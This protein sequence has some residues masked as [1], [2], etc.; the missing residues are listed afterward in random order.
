MKALATSFRIRHFEG[1]TALLLAFGLAG[2]AQAAVPAPAAASVHGPESAQ[3]PAPVVQHAP[4]IK[5]AAPRP[6]VKS[7]DWNRLTPSQRAAL[8]PLAGD[9][10]SLDSFRK[11]K[12]LELADRYATMSPAD[13]E[14]MQKRMQEWVR[15]SPE[16]RR[17]ARENYTRFKKLHPNHESRQWEQYQQLPEEKKKELA[18]SA[19][20]KKSI[21][22]PPRRVTKPAE[23]K[24]V[25]QAP[26]SVATPTPVPQPPAAPVQSSPS[27]P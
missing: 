22:N 7:T 1:V 6:A 4:V 21:V 24:P 17:I 19:Q 18:A 5:S 8:A 27:T 13:Q 10:N 3:T 9:W 25:T 20:P 23:H 16:Q 12:W 15:L 2:A 26:A 14:R 11:K